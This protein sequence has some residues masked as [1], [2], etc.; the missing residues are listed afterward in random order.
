[1]IEAVIEDEAT[2]RAVLTEIDG[3]VADDAI[4][5]SNT[6]SISITRLGAATRNP[7]RFVGMH[8]FNPVPAMAL[9]EV[10]RG[11]RTSDQTCERVRAFTTRIGKSPVVVNDFPGFVA[12]RIL[13]PM[14]NEAIFCLGE[15][16]ADRD[17]IDQVMTLGMAHP[18]GPLA[19][20]DLIG[21]DVCLNI[22]DVLHRDLGEDKYRPAPMLRRM[23]AAG[24]LG[25]KGGEGF[26]VYS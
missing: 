17:A 11:L 23:V 18:M 8:F 13:L 22:L 3:L 24:R 15:G 25:R 4:L 20:A 26:Y 21:L 5:A 10:V 2:K 7:A 19:L 14:I 16:V 12:N 9:V 1:M 6:S